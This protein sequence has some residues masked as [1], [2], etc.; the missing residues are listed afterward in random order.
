MKTI[1]VEAEF[2]V[3]GGGL[4]GLCAAVAAA[5]HGTK[6]VLVHDRPVLGGN[7]SSEIRVPVQGAYGSWDRSVRETG[8]IEEI[9]LE[10]LYRNP[11]GNWQM[12]DLAMHGIA[13]AEPN[14]TLLLNCSCTEAKASEG[15][16]E[17]LRA[18]QSTTQTWFEVSAQVFADCSGDSILSSFAG[19]EM[20]DGREAAAEFDEPLAPD[21]ASSTKM[22]MS[23][24]FVWRDLG[25]PQ[26]FMPPTWIHTFHNDEEA[27]KHVEKINLK[28]VSGANGFFVELGGEDD[29]IHDSEEIKEELLNLGLGLIDHYKN[30]GEHGAENLALEW[31]GFLPGKRESLRYVGDHMLRQS[32][33]QQPNAFEDIVA[34]GGWPID[35][36]DSKGSLRKGEYSHDWFKVNCPYGIPFRSLYSKN[37]E[38]LMMAGR[39]ISATHIALCTT[40]VMATCALLGQA[41]GTAASLS[42]R[43]ACTPRECGQLHIEELQASL[44][45]D[46]CWL[47]GLARAIPEPSRSASLLASSGDAELLRNGHD[48]EYEDRGEVNAWIAAKG[49]WVEYRF[50]SPQQLSQARI[51]F[52]SNLKRKWANM[53]L[54]YPRDGWDIKPEPTLVRGFRIMAENE[55]SEWQ[56]VACETDSFQRLVRLSLDVETKA[57]R[58]I[59]DETWG[60]D[61]VKVFAWDVS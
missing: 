5:R 53:P 15:R 60:H 39:N 23:L 8:I 22:G 10:T 12:W 32:D 9:M 35:D 36:H 42:I 48:R 49:A 18:W 28:P 41:I 33:V 20:R 61:S 14:L 54:W 27:P 47:P 38:N 44:Q 31:F 29:T 13:K 37:V 59:I 2:C 57:I 1:Q 55:S 6:T 26:R 51:V 50:E 56:E 58:L 17:S 40:R 21:V 16:L 7:A 3:V 25:S 34:Y 11:S 46:D 43:E 52:D 45:A 24:I 30:Q 4:A 19:A